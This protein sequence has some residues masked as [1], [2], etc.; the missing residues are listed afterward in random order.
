MAAHEH[1][2]QG[3]RCE[4][5]IKITSIPTRLDNK[6]GQH[7]VLWRDIQHI[8]TD[9]KAIFNKGEAVLFLTDDDFDYLTPLRIPHYP[10]VVLE[11]V[12]TNAHEDTTITVSDQADTSVEA[13]L[14][15]PGIQDCMSPPLAGK[16]L[17][18]ELSTLSLLETTDGDDTHLPCATM[19][20]DV[21]SALQDEQSEDS[22]AI[23]ANDPSRSGNNDT[24]S[25]DDIVV[26]S[27]SMA[28]YTDSS[29]RAYY[30]LHKAYVRAA[31]DGRSTQATAIECA[32]RG[33]FD[34]LEIEMSKIRD[35]HQQLGQTR[36]GQTA[37][38]DLQQQAVGEK[39]Q[40]GQTHLEVDGHRQSPSLQHQCVEELETKKQ[41]LFFQQQPTGEEQEQGQSVQPQE[42]TPSDRLSDIQGHIKAML[43][44]DYELHEYP[45]PRL[46]IVLPK[47]VHGA[48]KIVKP[49]AGQLRL[50]FLCDC[51]AHTMPEDGPT[52]HQVHLAA[53]KGY[54]ILNPVEFF[55][56]KLW[57]RTGLD[58]T[59]EHLES[60]VDDSVRFLQ[61]L[62]RGRI[63]NSMRLDRIEAVDRG[64]ARQLGWYLDVMKADHGFGNLYRII[65]R[66]GHVRWACKDHYIS[67]NPELTINEI[68]TDKENYFRP[69]LRELRRQCY[70]QNLQELGGATGISGL[71]VRSI[72]L[73]RI[74]IRPVSYHS[75][76]YQPDFLI[77]TNT[78]DLALDGSRHSCKQHEFDFIVKSMS[79]GRLRSLRF[80]SY[81][82]TDCATTIN[83]I[84][85]APMMRVLELQSPID[86]ES[87]AGMSYIQ[88]ILTCYRNL[89]YL[90]LRLKEQVSLV[91]VM[92]TAIP[93]LKKL[94]RLELYYSHFYMIADI[95]H[96]KIK[97]IQMY[98][99]FTK[100]H[101][102][103]DAKLPNYTDL[104]E[105]LALEQMAEIL[106]KE[107]EINGIKFG[108]RELGHLDIINVVLA[109]RQATSPKGDGMLLPMKL[110][111]FSLWNHL[112]ALSTSVI[113]EFTENGIETEVGISEWEQPFS[114]MYIDFFCKYGWSIKTL[115]VM[116]G[117]IDDSLAQIL[118]KSTDKGIELKSLT[119]D[120]KS[121]TLAGVQAIDKVIMRS[122]RLGCLGV[123]FAAS[124]FEEEKTRWFLEQ[125]KEKLTRLCLR[126]TDPTALTQWLEQF[127]PSRRAVPILSDLQ[128]RFRGSPELQYSSPFIQWLVGM[129]SAPHK[130][131][132]NSRTSPAMETSLMKCSDGSSTA[133]EVWLSLQRLHLNDLKS[134]DH[135]PWNWKA[136]LEV[137]DFSALEELDL[138]G[139]SFGSKDVQFLVN[140]IRRVNSYVPLKSLNLS[141]TPLSKIQA[142]YFRGAPFGT[143]RKKAPS[144]KIVGLRHLGVN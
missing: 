89:V 31:K 115:D 67:N 17:H 40:F 95:T 23:S 72:Q 135:E 8:F 15:E 44:Q 110:E 19:S 51:G 30:R 142:N 112:H 6:T 4:P 111:L 90:G 59:Q 57:D 75:Y 35:I 122:Q 53:H 41:Q 18:M 1:R 28:I 102:F 97:S 33:L 12:G 71:N 136:V 56:N 77:S 36:D 83:S 61:D 69:D 96:C 46:F 144:V 98:L 37:V 34:R 128:L 20:A 82:D 119:V 10:G 3:F 88:R 84:A 94:E 109:T 24:D 78:V 63:D 92:T 116:N 104:D 39:Q 2:A 137:I 52:F 120:L 124:D 103:E 42:H 80:I 29:I 123:I 131:T 93:K 114:A 125:H 133:N 5:S 85:N 74:V 50:Y 91:K 139:T 47:E 9:A 100:H 43:N 134:N 11:V 58:M 25:M 45:Y 129:I 99:P 76:T 87:E 32:M 26:Q 113:M 132:H 62:V 22:K 81:Q 141:D 79:N 101:I 118:D 66:N 27:E 13:T 121:L 16:S 138:K 127:F 140:C 86:A 117:T 38:S 73:L 14:Q 60:L 106:Y 49:L 107:P 48:D 70:I 130:P 126:G 54:D 143:I 55:D 105:T 65:T 21:E 68:K 64:E 108:Y 7:I